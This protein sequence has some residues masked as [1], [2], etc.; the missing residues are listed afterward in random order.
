MNKTIEF[1]KADTFEAAKAKAKADNLRNRMTRLGLVGTVDLNV[2]TAYEVTELDDIY[3]HVVRTYV[4][5][6]LTYSTDISLGEYTLV[7]TYDFAAVPG[8]ALTFL[9]D[10]EVRILDE[11]DNKRCDHCGRRTERNHVIVVA[12]ADGNQI[13]VGGQCS[14]DFL[15]H[16]AAK[17]LSFGEAV[18][19]DEDG[20]F[21]S[22][23]VPT[24][25]FITYAA[26]AILAE[27]YGK[28]DSQ[29]PTKRTAA[30]LTTGTI[31]GEHRA[32]IE[33]RL[34][35]RN[36]NPAEIA[37]AAIAWAADLAPVSD[38]EANLA[39]VARSDWLGERAFGIAAYIPEAYLRA[40]AKAAEKAAEES[41]EVPA[42]PA[43]EGRVE[44]TGTVLSVK[45]QSNDF[46]DRL[47]WT[48]RSDQGFRVWSTVPAAIAGEVEA[49]DTVTFTATLT[50]S[51]DD[52][53][54]AFGKRPSKAVV[55]A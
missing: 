55:A 14:I 37:E 8:E 48:V 44:I 16:N 10:D 46:G 6:T 7:G 5:I 35:R 18:L 52:N 17:I 30:Q 32:Y 45:V 54:F 39:K 2:G 43:P 20:P 38:F 9:A 33:E 47:V 40:Q 41:A 26:T 50:P 36:V 27:G 22:Y 3:G 51:D 11:A 42:S 13:H 4:D 28:A 31:D 15:G 1:I 23:E 21:N 49:G 24:G 12:D 29:N 19:Q 53:T 34:D 25:T